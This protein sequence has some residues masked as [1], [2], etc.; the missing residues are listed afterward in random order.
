MQ[1]F[2][3]GGINYMENTTQ[4][5][6]PESG[7]L[8]LR[9]KIAFG[10]G[11]FGGN[12]IFSTISSFAMLYFTDVAG[13]SVGA[14]A[15]LLMIA[16]CFDGITDIIMGHLIDRTHTKMGKARP[17]I[18]WSAFPMAAA[19]I[20]LFHVPQSLSPTAKNIYI[21]VFYVLVCA[22]FYTANNIAY[23]SLTSLM[24]DDAKERVSMGSIRF[25]FTAI[26]GI[27]IGSFTTIL[28]EKFGNGQAGWTAVILLYTGV[29]LVSTMLCV[30]GVKE[31]N[32]SDAFEKKDEAEQGK[33]KISFLQSLKLLV[34]NKYF[35]LILGVFLVIY[36]YT[37]ALGTSGVYYATWVLGDAKLYGLLS[38][39]MMIPM[40]LSLF[41]A[42]AL[43]KKL[44]M[45]KTC[46]LAAVLF[47]IGSIITFVSKT[48]L[49]LILI[50]VAVRSIGMGPISTV[51]FAEIAEVSD[52]IT[53][54]KHKSIEGM[55]FSC[56]SIGIKVGTGLGTAI[57]GWL[58]DAGS[59]D[60]TLT[61]QPDSAI[62]M[63]ITSYCGIPL[64]IGIAVFILFWFI[65]VE[66]KNKKL[67]LAQKI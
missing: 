62:N 12:F 50:G 66:D 26:A 4:N 3:Y 47:V 35:W 10:L 52:N 13:A 43:S 31:R 56:S 30:F 5:I 2:M 39:A 48:S 24:T 54:T 11:D 37:G 67:K 22:F 16:K 17:W 61:V 65:D 28:V 29:F 46:L 44:G 9:E 41:F 53:L 55:V 7:K 45:R 63:I 42:S 58:M 40:L 1:K 18:F 60:G 27:I 33:G 59:Y 21:F 34:T 19:M 57:V 8:K 51:I 25:I 20:M 23:N 49:L 15:T 32:T 36:I 14:V 38:L 6:K 64:I